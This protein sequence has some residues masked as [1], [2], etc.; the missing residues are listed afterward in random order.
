MH[1]P[2]PLPEDIRRSNIG[3]TRHALGLYALLVVQPFIGWVATSA[4]RA[5]IMVF[6]LFELPRFGLRTAPCPGVCSWFML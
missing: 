6:G 2:L 1:P 5:P 4:Y 3:R